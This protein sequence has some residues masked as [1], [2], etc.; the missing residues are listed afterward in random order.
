VARPTDGF[1]I[2]AVD[3]C[4][5]SADVT[6]SGL[7]AQ[8]TS[9][10]ITDDLLNWITEKTADAKA[11][12]D[13]VV[14]FQHHGIIPHYSTQ[15]MIAPDYVL[16]NW[17]EAGEAYADAGIRYVFSGHGHAQ[18]IVSAT[19]NGNTIYDVETNSLVTYPSP[20]RYV[21][22][23]NGTNMDG[24]EAEQVDVVTDFI[25]Q[26]FFN[27][28]WI[29]DFTEY[30]RTNSVDAETLL[31][32]AF[33][34]AGGLIM[35]VLA[36]LLGAEH[37]PYDSGVTHYG[38]RALIEEMLGSDIG[39]YAV[40]MLSSMLPSSND[41]IPLEI[42]SYN[43]KLYYDA[44]NRRVTVDVLG[45]LLGMLYMTDNNIKSYLIDETFV[46][47]DRDFL[48]N[49]AYITGAFIRSLDALCRQYIDAEH[50]F[51]DLA[52]YAYLTNIDGNAGRLE[53]WAEAAMYNLIYGGLMDEL[54]AVFNA[55]LS[56]EFIDMFRQIPVN[57]NSLIT[58]GGLLG[59]TIKSAAVSSLPDNVYDFLYIYNYR[60]S[61][62]YHTHDIDDNA[63]ILSYSGESAWPGSDLVRSGGCHVV[64]HWRH[65]TSG[66][67]K[68][69]CGQGKCQRRAAG[70]NF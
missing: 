42:G 65:Y 5:Y 64:L 38:S 54:I 3:A 41:P 2:I 10:V 57:Y 27:G 18:S 7:D 15:L 55:N 34:Q 14:V 24:Y 43:A 52:A 12:G 25:T 20:I 22:V 6:P 49:P 26:I 23:T 44:S 45:S 21:T 62:R 31:P 56:E 9:G 50:R 47:L 8:V 69:V 11:A 51:Y 68:R 48:N 46:R 37:T 30:G 53:P 32:S 70:D 1:T 16:D 35:D 19:Y 4:K 39:N 66:G 60:N 13:M 28:E 61:F 17:H 40:D 63:N 29:E 36:P 67:G 33:G 59:S 58:T